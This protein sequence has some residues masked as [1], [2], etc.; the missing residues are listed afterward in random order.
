M[1]PFNKPQ[2]YLVA[3]YYIYHTDAKNM[4]VYLIDI[5]EVKK[6]GWNNTTIKFPEIYT[7]NSYTDA[8]HTYASMNTPYN[9]LG[10]VLK[11]SLTGDRAKI[12]NPVYEQ[13]RKLR[14]NQPK[15]QYQ[16]LCVSFEFF[17]KCV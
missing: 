12:R 2:L 11:N 8:I 13:V 7:M 5:N 1:V 3:V 16:Y 10:V 15:L 4:M 14:G 17:L 9:I 6:F